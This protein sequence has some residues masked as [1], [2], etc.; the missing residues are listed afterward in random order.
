MAEA[1]GSNTSPSDFLLLNEAVNG[2]KGEIEAFKRHMSDD[3]LRRLIDSSVA[4]SAD[5]TTEI[6]ESLQEAS[7][8]YPLSCTVQTAGILLGA[9]KVM[10]H[11]RL[12]ENS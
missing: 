8:I 3:R 4:G 1:L 6:L 2:A 10:S 11:P 5:A 7:S 12:T 9:R